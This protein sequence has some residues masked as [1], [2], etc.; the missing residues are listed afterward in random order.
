M[1]Q[2]PNSLASLPPIPQNVP[3]LAY[4]KLE[5]GVN[6]WIVDNVLT[7]PEEVKE[8]CLNREKWEYGLPYQPESWPGMR[9]HGAL[10]DDEI[11]QVETLVKKL[12]GK[13][14]LWREQ[15]PG[16][17]RLDCNVAQ[18][19]GE[20]ESTSHP[21]TDSRN[22]CRY[23]CVIYLNPTPAPNSGTSFCRL[24]YPNGAIGGNM[25]VAPYN[26]LGDA[27]RVK[28]LPIQAWFEDM[29]VENVFNRMILYKANIVHCATGYFGKELN[30]KRLTTV[31]FWMT[32]D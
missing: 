13:D 9:F 22:L 19:V 12:T 1:I 20:K 31:F 32:E 7:N 14:K 11:E 16:G 10:T 25:V 6:Y 27:L 15:P 2:I 8:R 21:H 17:L 26:N 29:R 3:T 30:D 23:A 4:E 5:H 24:R 18:L 28:G